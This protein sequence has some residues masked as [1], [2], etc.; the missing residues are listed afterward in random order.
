MHTVNT[1]YIL[2]TSVLLCPL[3][4]L[5]P[6]YPNSFISVN[7][8]FSCKL[9]SVISPMTCLTYLIV[10]DNVYRITVFNGYYS[11]LHIWISVT[12]VMLM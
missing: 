6:F 12:N 1:L 9:I 3:S 5:F 10:F 2:S 4:I 7:I 8:F 11:I